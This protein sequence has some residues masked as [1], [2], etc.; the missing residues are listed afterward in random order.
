M[1][2][3]LIIFTVINVILAAVDAAKIKKGK[4]ISHGINAAVY[5]AAVAATYFLFH[6]FWLIGALL[7]NRLLVFNI[8]LSLFRGLPFDYITPVPAAITDKIAK[9]IFGRN[10]KLMYLFYLII[11]TGF[12]VMALK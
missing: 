6:N 2:E 10:G 12:I 11:F 1:I 9:A 3:T 4:R 8:A 5:I 7:F